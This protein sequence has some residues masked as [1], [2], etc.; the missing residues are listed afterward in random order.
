ME[1]PFLKTVIN[2]M[3]TSTTVLDQSSI[4][5]FFDF[6]IDLI[7]IANTEGCFLK[8]NPAFTRILGFS[9]EELINT[10]FTDYVHPDDEDRTL[11]EVERLARGMKTIMFENRYRTRSGSYRWL[12][13]TCMPDPETGLLYAIA[14]DNTVNKQMETEL[15]E[16]K[17]MLNDV[18]NH[19]HV[20]VVIANEKGEFVV[21]NDE[22]V[23]I[24]GLGMM[25]GG[26]D[27]WSDHFGIYHVGGKEKMKP[28]DLPLVKALK[29]ETVAQQL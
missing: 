27:Y 14:R 25:K 11:I 19:L 16:T 9:E 18:I 15:M 1:S 26:S 4:M 21:F 3:Q 29:G 6:S 22:A 5:K 7:F 17:I 13:W 28:E 20:G 12:A 24:V 23:K 2:T 8:V 10:P